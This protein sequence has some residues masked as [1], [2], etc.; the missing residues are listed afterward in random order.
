[1]FVLKIS[2]NF[3]AAKTLFYNKPKHF[4]SFST[5]NLNVYKN[6]NFNIF[7]KTSYCHNVNFSTSNLKLTDNR[8]QK[9][10]SFSSKNNYGNAFWYT[11]SGIVLFFGA[12]YLAVPLYKM[13]CEIQG[14][15]TNSEFRDM[16]EEAIRERL[17]NMKKID[18]RKIKVT[19]VATTSSDLLWKFEPQQNEIYL[20][21]GE[22]A[23]AFYRARNL[24]DHSIIGI[25]T[26]NI[27]PFEAALYFNKVQCF[28]F[29]EQR[30]EPNEEVDMPVFFFI[31]EE[32]AKDPLLDEVDSICLSY[33][34]FESKGSE[35][36]VPKIPKTF[37]K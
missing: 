21:P 4:A 22:T 5:L 29:E 19:F 15:D 13:F 27:L 23:L 6:K 24:T 35:N 8:N 18:N 36:E 28:C 14:I 37:F 30:L 20:S 9:F 10:R 3:N 33:T 26:Y 2:R 7:V 12:T 34:F 25:A 11:L 31:D 1:M 17:K 32:Y 16:P